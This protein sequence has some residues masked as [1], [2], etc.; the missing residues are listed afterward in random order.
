MILRRNSRPAKA[1]ARSVRASSSRKSGAKETPVLRAANFAP[2][3]WLVHA[4]STRKGGVSTA[5]GRASLNL[6]HT[7]HDSAE[8]VLRNRAL[9]A[10]SA[11]ARTGSHTWPFAEVRQIH[12]SIIHHVT[13]AP[14][15]PLVG[16]GMITRV[17]G[18]LL[19]I[20]TADCIPVLIGDVKK[21]AVGAF[22]AGWRGTAARIV[23]KG[24][25]DMRLHFGSNPGDLVAAIGPG[26]HRC[27]YT[28]NED[29]VHE[30][31]SQFDYW[32]ELFEEVY[33]FESLHNKYPMLF[34][35]QRAPGHGNAA[36]K[37]QLDLVEANRRQLLRAGVLPGNISAAEGC[38]S[39]ETRTFFSHRA[40][41]GHPGRMMA[42]IGIKP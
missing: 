3:P 27:C 13:T 12:S 5:Y 9:F 7:D 4:F 28:V 10:K 14:E 31:E 41:H 42:A 1:P 34:L 39:C 36:T 23:E 21:R 8:N 6:G 22:H 38:T 18:L 20:K 30:F 29:L 17:P 33:D 24:V 37:I 32:K 25:G 16:D 11:G 35:N 2:F 40:E 15:K 19:V 26:I